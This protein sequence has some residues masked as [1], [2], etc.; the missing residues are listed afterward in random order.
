V[1]RARSPRVGPEEVAL[2]PRSVSKEPISAPLQLSRHDAHSPHSPLNLVTILRD[3][4]RL[5]VLVVVVWLLALVAGA[6]VTFQV[7]SLPAKLE[8]RSYQ[9]GV[10]TTRVLIDTPSSQVVDV[11]PKG[12][13]T[14]GVRANLIA[15]LMVDGA[16]KDAIA[17]R[18]GLRLDQLVGV[19]RNDAEQSQTSRPSPRRGANVLTTRLLSN[20]DGDQLPIVEIDTQAADAER[21]AALANAAVAGLREYLDKQA[22][23]ERVPPARRL[24]VSGLGAAQASEVTRGPSKILALAVVLVVF[25]IGCALILGGLAI[26]RGW[27]ALSQYNLP[28]EPIE[29]FPLEPIDDDDDTQA[30]DIDPDPFEASDW[31]ARP[32]RAEKS[33]SAGDVE[34]RAQSA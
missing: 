1:P 30:G 13:D 8:S 21:A 34:D 5:R 25:G 16:F 10:A 11:S 15:S 20:V 6:A 3:L 2:T 12:S 31:L 33:R 4:W 9:V 17:R 27:R 26:V 24:R 19:A 23:A 29:D 32:L 7:F 22:A 18:A 28:L 14:L